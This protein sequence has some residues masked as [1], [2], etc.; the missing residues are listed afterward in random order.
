MLRRPT[1]LFRL[2]ELP[3]L[4]RIPANIATPEN[5]NMNATTLQNTL[6]L[7]SPFDLETHTLV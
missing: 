6:C 7:T 3:R 5:S 4:V 2:V 1:I